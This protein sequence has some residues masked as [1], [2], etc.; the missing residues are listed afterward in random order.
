MCAYA[1]G[2]CAGWRSP[3]CLPLPH[4]L[5]PLSRPCSVSCSASP[6]G[7]PPS[8]L[9]VLPRLHR[10]LSASPE[11]VPPS[12]SP[13]FLPFA[14][15]LPLPLCSRSALF[16]LA[17]PSLV[18]THAKDC[19]APS[20]LLPLSLTRELCRGADEWGGHLLHPHDSPA[21]MHALRATAQPKG[22]QA[23][24]FHSRLTHEIHRHHRGRKAP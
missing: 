3:L 5:A 17:P 22:G 12:L 4:V 15:A 10:P 21:R 1:C 9:S 16:P 14:L 13:L 6:E 24:Q 7:V 20:A 2:A 11:G 8:L 23:G 19:P 18:P